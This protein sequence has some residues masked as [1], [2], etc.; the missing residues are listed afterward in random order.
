MSAK[1]RLSERPDDHFYAM[2]GAISDTPDDDLDVDDRDVASVHAAEYFMR[3]C[4]AKGDFSSIH[5]SAPR[6]GDPGRGWRPAAGPLP[7]VLPWES[8]DSCQSGRAFASHIQLD[9]I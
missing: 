6:S 5:S 9:D 2:V 1:D 7:A 4:E 3:V 8:P